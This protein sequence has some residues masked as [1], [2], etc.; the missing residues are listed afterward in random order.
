M[1]K[2]QK[3]ETLEDVRHA[4]D[5]FIGGV[6]AFGYFEMQVENL[7]TLVDSSKQDKWSP[8]NLAAEV[9]LIGLSAYFEAF[10]K[11]HFAA[12]TNICPAIIGNFVERRPN[13]TLRLRSLLSARAE[14]ASKLENLI[15]E[16]YDFGSA[17]EINGMHQDLMRITP[18]SVN[19]AKKYAQ[20]LSDRNLLVH[21]GGV[22]TYTYSAQRF[23]R[24]TVRGLV[25]WDSL[26]IG[27]KEFTH[28]K[29]FVFAIAQK[30]ASTS[31]TA[32]QEFATREKIKLNGEQKKALAMLA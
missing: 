14:I 29:S 20:F 24:R 7:V 22:Y 32:L 25:H 13:A 1:R 5:Y 17:R 28:W 27:K 31:R 3:S 23:A 16:E 9:S 6:L 26:V 19:D 15:S 30:I 18:F 21:H 2:S 8:L 11:A 12:L 4:L 10:C